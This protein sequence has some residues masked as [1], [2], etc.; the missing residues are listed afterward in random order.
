VPRVLIAAHYASDRINGEGLIPLQIFRRLRERDLDPMLLTHD[1]NEAELRDTF[2]DAAD[3]LHFVSSLPGFSPVFTM[4]ERLPDGPRT[5]AWGVTQIERQLAMLPRI[6]RL[7]AEHSIDV[8]HQ[9]VGISPSVPSPWVRLGAPL[10]VGPL[11]DSVSMPPAFAQR[12]SRGYRLTRILRD[13]TSSAANR[14]MPGK[15]RATT[16]LVANERTAARLPKGVTGKVV[17]EQAERV[18]LPEWP[19]RKPRSADGPVVFAFLGR[20]VR[21]KSADYLIEAV[22]RI[23]RDVDIRVEIIGDGPEAAS[24]KELAHARGVADRV[25]FAGWLRAEE[26][27]ERL[28]NADVFV[29]PSLREAGGTS[30]IEAMATALPVIVADWGGPSYLVDTASGVKLPVDSPESFVTALSDAMV[31]LA[32]DPEL[33]AEL[34]RGGRS[35]V[36]RLYDWELLTD[37]LIAMY[38]DAASRSVS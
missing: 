1:S 20:L 7:V 13:R 31:R 32:Q 23:G 5:I 6:R 18:A 30:V 17:I 24:L 29:S 25:V 27:A 3:R 4:G 34:G 36:E 37:H 35:R 14:L 10:V 15:L 12:D 11:L 26:A 8:V 21:L 19:P 28:R 38:E 2:R 9:P 16:I 33:R 22:A